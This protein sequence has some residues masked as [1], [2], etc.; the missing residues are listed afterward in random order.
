MCA[1]MRAGVGRRLLAAVLGLAAGCA[2]PPERS[3]EDAAAIVGGV[4]SPAAR[5]AV[6]RLRQPGGTCSATLLAPN[7]LLTAR[8]CVTAPPATIYNYQCDPNGNPVKPDGT[9]WP[10]SDA[11]G[12][13]LDPAAIAARS[14]ALGPNAP[15]PASIDDPVA[16][17]GAQLFHSAGGHCQGDI[18]LVPFAAACPSRRCGSSCA[19]ALAEYPWPLTAPTAA[20]R[21]P[22]AP[23][24]PGSAA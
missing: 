17:H 7:L 5:D 2:A 6:I 21:P 4:D 11:F 15:A 13:D 20:L 1:G 18:A 3:G 14:G 19:A 22:T 10:G 12:K 9:P 8:H 16:A 23:R 24:D